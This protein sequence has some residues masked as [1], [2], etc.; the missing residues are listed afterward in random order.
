[1]KDKK[2]CNIKFHY[3]IGPFVIKS[4][5]ALPIVEKLLESLNFQE[6]QR[7]NYNPKK[8]IANGKKINRCG[9]FEHHEIK[10]FPSLANAEDVIDEDCI[11]DES[12]KAS[13]SQGFVNKNNLQR[14]D[15]QTPM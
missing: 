1:M 13:E 10:G 6:A 5:L 4:S 9:T 2:W 8:I 14:L 15:I 12:S 7:V 11:A 3:A